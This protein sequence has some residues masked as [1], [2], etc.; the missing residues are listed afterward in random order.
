MGNEKIRPLRGVHSD[1][2][3]GGDSKSVCGDNG[4]RLEKLILV[5]Q[6]YGYSRKFWKAMMDGNQKYI[7]SLV[8]RGKV[9]IQ[10]ISDDK[11]VARVE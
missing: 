4:G 3:L 11:A 6:S 9:I 1:A 8:K 2:V 5:Q 10:D 7:D